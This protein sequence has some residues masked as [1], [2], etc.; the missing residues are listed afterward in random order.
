MAD[1]ISTPK[2]EW[3]PPRDALLI[4]PTKEKIPTPVDA[5]G[6]VIVSQL[7]RDVRATVDPSYEWPTLFPD[8]HHLYHYHADYPSIEEPGRVN[9]RVFC[10]LPINRRMMP[11]NFHN[12]IHLVAERPAVPSEEVMAYRIQAYEISRG[13]FVSARWLIQLE[14]MAERRLRQARQNE[15]DGREVCLKGLR[16]SIDRHRANIDRHLELVQTIPPELHIVPIDSEQRVERIARNLG[17]FVA[18]K[19]IIEPVRIAA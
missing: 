7:V 6:L 10:N 4:D 1:S 9:P 18:K 19:R 12:L 13:L 17:K 11:R 3:L 8:D 15:I 14:R 5:N 16:V 2:P